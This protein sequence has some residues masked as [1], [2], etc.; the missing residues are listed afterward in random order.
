MTAYQ[1]AAR[2]VA[3]HAQHFATLLLLAAALAATTGNNFPGQGIG[4][5]ACDSPHCGAD[6]QIERFEEV[7][8]NHSG[9]GDD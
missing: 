7:P 8:C 1:L 2:F 6:R 3:K 4:D 9:C 5:L